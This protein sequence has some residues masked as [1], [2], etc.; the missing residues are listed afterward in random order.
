[1]NNPTRTLDLSRLSGGSPGITAAYG[2]S[3]A[4]AARV[5]LDDQGHKQGVT[6]EVNG[7]YSQD[8][9]I[10][11]ATPTSQMRRTWA[12]EEYATE[13][14]AYGIAALLVEEL[15]AFRLVERSRKGTGFD[16]WLSDKG[17]PGPLF[18]HKSRLE[19]SGIRNGTETQIDSRVR[20]KSR[21]IG[22][23]PSKLAGVVVVVE[24]GTPQSRM[25]DR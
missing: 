13:Q 21:Q 20:A 22:A 19:V 14:G 7:D 16:Y 1:M 4:Q 10:A 24:F 3:M 17:D 18:Q 12:D 25:A 5:C 23:V 8:F 6:M 9:K 11:F 2:E 15:T